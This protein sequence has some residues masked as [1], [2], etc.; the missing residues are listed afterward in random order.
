MSVYSRERKAQKMRSSLNGLQ[1]NQRLQMDGLKLLEIL[2]S[3]AAVLSFLDPQYR[4]VLDKLTYGN[5][6][7]QR[8]QQRAALQ[9]MDETL[10][11]T[12]IKGIHKALAPMGHLFLWMDKFHLCTGFSKW[13]EDT[14]FEVVDLITW[15]KA[16]MGMGYRTRRCSEYL[17]VLQKPPK[18]AKDVW[19]LHDIPD[20]WEEKPTKNRH[21]HAKPIEL[22]SRLIEA[23]SLPEDLVVDPAAGSFSVLK[24]CQQTGRTFVGCDING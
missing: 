24:A 20:V 3:E 21:T 19:Q 2:P 14:D 4:G 10:I 6:G 8:G 22:Q 15:Y 7:E 5:E 13:I 18:R 16:R 1:A 23:V 12:F 9:Q 17:A 11:R